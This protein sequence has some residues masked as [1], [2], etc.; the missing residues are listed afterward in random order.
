VI[1]A[2][3]WFERHGGPESAGK[4]SSPM[5]QS[6]EESYAVAAASS[7]SCGM[8]RGCQNPVVAEVFR[9]DLAKAMERLSI[10]GLSRGTLRIFACDQHVK[11]RRLVGI[12]WQF[13]LL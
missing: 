8:V 10:Q 6:P 3:L 9:A 4:M 11:D 2:Q 1:W 13:L 12:R 7:G 5:Q